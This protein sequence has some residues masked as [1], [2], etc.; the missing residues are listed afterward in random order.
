VKISGTVAKVSRIGERWRAE[1][2]LSAGVDALVQGQAGAGI[3]ST[4]IVA[5]RSITV[6]GIVRRPYPTASDRRFAVLPRSGADITLGSGGSANE[7]GAGGRAGGATS[8]SG[9]P[10][11]SA[12][13]I[14]PDTD[15]ATLADLVGQRVKV[16]GLVAR[17]ADDGFDLDDGTALARVQL[18]GDL[19]ALLPHLRVGEAIAAAGRVELVDKAPVVVVD[20]DGTLV[21]VGTLGQALPI[22]DGATLDPSEAPGGGP[23]AADS[24]GGVGGIGGPAPVSLLALASLTALSVL[25]TVLRR[26]L[27][28][29]RLRLALVE[30]LAT[31]PTRRAR[32]ASADPGVA[33][34]VSPPTAEHESA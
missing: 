14:T 27:L 21:R 26:R 4:S 28:Q 18:R 22:G 3:P 2:T 7:A 31:L 30:R 17:F 15:L 1:I 29:R 11:A 13:A 23:V 12:A 9:D 5:G 33:A 20:A 10:A 16:G 32:I 34:S 6:T 25:A 19:L 24:S 8:S